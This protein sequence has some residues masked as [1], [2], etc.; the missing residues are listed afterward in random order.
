MAPPAAARTARCSAAVKAA[1]S[2]TRLVGRRHHQH[3]IARRS[4]MACS[5]ASVIAGAVLRPDRLQQ[6]GGRRQRQA[7]AAGPA[8]GS[9]VPRCPPRTGRRLAMSRCGQ[10]LQAQRGLLE[11]AA[12]WPDSARNCFGIA[13]ARQRPQP[14]AAAAGHDH[15]LQIDRIHGHVISGNCASGRTMPDAAWRGSAWACQRSRWGSCAASASCR[16]TCGP[17][18]ARPASPAA[19]LARR[20][21]GIAGGHVARAARHRP[22]RA[23]SRPLACGIGAHHLEHAVA[24]AGAQV[25]GERAGRRRTGSAAPPHGLRPGRMTWM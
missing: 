24:P 7:R 22:G 13:G 9:G 1:S 4:A 16:R 19:A 12:C 8:P 3:R 25:D 21:V 18:R 10:R 2:V 15:G 6:H 11:Q 14:R 20:G 5:A 17:G 23:P